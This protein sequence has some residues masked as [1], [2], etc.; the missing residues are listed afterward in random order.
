MQNTLNFS[1]CSAWILHGV[2]LV[3]LFGI[4]SSISTWIILLIFDKGI[5]GK[6]DDATFQFVIEGNKLIPV[7]GNEVNDYFIKLVE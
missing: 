5:K 3:L 6:Y 7:G 4:I 2:C 1:D